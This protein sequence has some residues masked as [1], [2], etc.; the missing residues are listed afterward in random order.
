VARI[1]TVARRYAEAVFGLAA[2]DSSYDAWAAD[3]DRLGALLDVPI[4]SK[5]LMSPAVP[6]REKVNVIAAAADEQPD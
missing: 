2:Q 5:A 1:R 3:L 4:V 6:A